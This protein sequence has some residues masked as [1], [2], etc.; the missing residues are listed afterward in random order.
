MKYHIHFFLIGCLFAWSANPVFSQNE[1]VRISDE[2]IG[3]HITGDKKI[4]L[5]EGEY[6]NLKQYKRLL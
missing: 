1:T 2:E 5:E 4:I 6:A 3:L